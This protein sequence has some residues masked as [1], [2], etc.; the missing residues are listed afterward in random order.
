MFHTVARDFSLCGMFSHLIGERAALLVC[1]SG[2]AMNRLFLGI[3]GG[4]SSTT[5]FL[6]D[7][8]GR[9]VGLGRAG[10][11][12]HVGA[13]LGRSRFLSAVGD[14]VRG[15]LEAAGLAHDT[16]FA[17][18]YL[19]LSGGPAD[20]ESLVR[21]LIRA[22]RYVVTHDAAI[23]LAGATSGRPGIVTIAGTGSI[24]FGRN[25][26]GK[27]ARAGGW[28]YVFGD[29][30][31]AFDLV[32][33]AVRAALRHEEG[34]GPRTALG[35]LLI[36]AA[37][38]TTP[39]ELLHR[40]YTD[41][42]P[43]ARIAA[44]APLV[45]QAAGAGDAVA[46]GILGG[47]AQS[48]ASLTGA[49]RGQLFGANDRVEVRYSGGVFRSAPLLARY[50]MLVEIGGECVAAKPDFCPAA[51]ALIEAYR[52]AGVVCTLKDAPAFAD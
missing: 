52:A 37:G 36:E 34:W 26:A 10:P 13:A 48:L 6:G 21:T 24:A 1:G 4:Q 49:V 27:T 32:R 31:S 46:Q 9:V 11:C 7:E 15:A 41:E 42:Y 35:E 38:A 22:E 23:A 19:G 40:F 14:S 44:L 30:G 45:D 8:T 3:D 20:K 39:N 25:A 2:P 18:A 50:T 16:E 51:G 5:C 28:G 33:Q 43:R 29:E 17:S 12:N 47:A